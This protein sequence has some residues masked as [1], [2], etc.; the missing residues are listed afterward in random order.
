MSKKI[1]I[2]GHGKKKNG[3]FDSG[4]INK[5]GIG[6]HKYFSDYIFPMMK[7][8]SD[9]KDLVLFNDYNVFDYGNIVSLAKSYGSDSQIIELHFDSSNS[10][11]AKGGH[12]II[13]SAFKPDKFDL[14]LLK[15]ITD[16]IGI[17]TS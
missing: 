15:M 17:R 12:I 4:A 11:S 2:V 6:E 10:V 7:K 13:S 3:T 1:F 5:V 16:T 14:N 8:L 9:D